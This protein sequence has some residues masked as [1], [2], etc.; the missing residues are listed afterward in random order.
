MS[1]RSN[2]EFQAQHIIFALDYDG[3]IYHASN[4]ED[5]LA[6]NETLINILADM[7]IDGNYKTARIVS[8]SKRQS[9]LEEAIGVQQ[10]QAMPSCKAYQ[11]LSQAIEDLVINKMHGK[12]INANCPRIILDKLLLSDV[13]GDKLKSSNFDRI[14]AAYER[15]GLMMTEEDAWSC[16]WMIDTSKWLIVDYHVNHFSHLYRKSYGSDKV[17]Y[18]F[19]DNLGDEAQ[20]I[21]NNRLYIDDETADPANVLRPLITTFAN[22]PSLL[23]RNMQFTA[24][25]YFCI[26][27]K[28]MTRYDKIVG[29]GKIPSENKAITRNHFTMIQRCLYGQ[30][31]FIEDT[32]KDV[33][34]HCTNSAENDGQFTAELNYL[35]LFHK[36][37]N[38]EN[39]A[40][41][42]APPVQDDN[43]QDLPDIKPSEAG[44]FAKYTSNKSTQPL[45]IQPLKFHY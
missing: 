3:T 43:D 37:Q 39:S 29:T 28:I 10:Y 35:Q 22:S 16:D 6:R 24:Y 45:E 15:D 20:K 12:N 26:L 18:V 7:I 19:L 11:I 36:W 14:V 40:K 44:L 13:H 17:E 8:G 33:K 5:F 25:E 2:P 32:M 31:L 38:S 41:F 27:Q 4:T 23:P 30:N 21:N 34:R 9:Y 42:N 1:F